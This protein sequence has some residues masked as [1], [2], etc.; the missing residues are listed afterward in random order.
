MRYVETLDLG[1]IGHV[2][3]ANEAFRPFIRLQKL[4]LADASLRTL[5]SNWFDDS[6]S[7]THLD[8]S[9]NEFT[10]IQRGHLQSLKK[11]IEINFAD[12]NIETI[13]SNAFGDTPNLEKLNFHFNMLK[14]I[15]NMGELF[16]LKVLDL[17]ANSITEVSWMRISVKIIKLIQYH[18][19]HRFRMEYL[20]V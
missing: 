4:N 16:Y 13:E 12:N 6:N 8:I 20:M 14:R 17:S 1:N 18:P 10:V 19:I 2:T 11:L 15:S 9:H 3:I 7:I 5:N